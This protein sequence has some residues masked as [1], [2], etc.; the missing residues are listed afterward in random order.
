MPIRLRPIHIYHFQCKHAPH[1]PIV[2]HLMVHK[3]L[4][5]RLARDI[6]F[7]VQRRAFYIHN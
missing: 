4:T 3:K 7:R 1:P 2:S 5:A 6:R